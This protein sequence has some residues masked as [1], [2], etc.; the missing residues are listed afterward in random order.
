MAEYKN[1]ESLRNEVEQKKLKLQ[2]TERQLNRTKNQ[3]SYREGLSRKARNH[4]LIICGAIFEK[5]FPMIR[6]LTEPE[7]SEVLSITDISGFTQELTA[8]ISKVRK[9]V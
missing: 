6:D 7:L 3:L 2:Q 4:R 8:G 1:L 5:Y 9:E